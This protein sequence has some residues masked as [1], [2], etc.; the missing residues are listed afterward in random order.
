MSGAAARRLYA[1]LNLFPRLSP[2]GA[3]ILAIVTKLSSKLVR[4]SN[5]RDIR[6]EGCSHLTSIRSRRPSKSGGAVI[7]ANA[8]HR[9]AFRLAQPSSCGRLTPLAGQFDRWS[10]V[11]G[12]PRWSLRASGP[13][14]WRFL[15]AG[16][17]T[18]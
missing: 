6:T 17:D 8:G 2:G 12:T 13:A 9:G 3:G 4:R 1:S 18:P 10:F 14:A 7:Y 15:I 16:N 11:T 5:R